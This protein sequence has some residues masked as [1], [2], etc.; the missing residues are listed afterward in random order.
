MTNLP[1]TIKEKL[2]EFYESPAINDFN[3]RTTSWKKKEIDT[4]VRSLV[5]TVLEGVK[6]GLPERRQTEVFHTKHDGDFIKNDWDDCR[7]TILTSLDKA[8]AEIKKIP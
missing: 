8:I 7:A 5:L 2:A 1:A 4:L 6:D 3:F